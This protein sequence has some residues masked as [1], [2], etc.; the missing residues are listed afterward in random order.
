MGVPARLGSRPVPSRSVPRSIA[1]FATRYPQQFQPAR[2]PDCLP[3]SHRTPNRL[4]S[5]A[6]REPFSASLRLPRSLSYA[7]S[8]FRRHPTSRHPQSTSLSLSFISLASAPILS[9]FLSHLRRGLF[10]SLSLSP[11]QI[12]SVFVCTTAAFLCVSLCPI[13]VSPRPPLAVELHSANAQAPAIVLSLSDLRR[14][15][16]VSLVLSRVPA[17]FSSLAPSPFPCLVCLPSSHVFSLPPS[18]SP[19]HSTLPPRSARDSA[20]SVAPRQPTVLPLVPQLLSRPF[21]PLSSPSRS[22]VTPVCTPAVT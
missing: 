12:Y 3:V 19:R 15:T 14:L 16:L 1:P 9:L 4:H 6:I 21:V 22:G 7:L 11:S 20:V 10:P 18:S 2:P 13:E 8:A 5:E 17:P